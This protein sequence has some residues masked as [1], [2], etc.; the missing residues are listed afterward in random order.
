MRIYL[1]LFYSFLIK[2]KGVLADALYGTRDFMDKA[3][4]LTHGAQVISQ[5]RS[6]QCVLSK[7]SKTSVDKFFARQSGVKTQLTIRGGKTQ[8]VTLL[9]LRLKVKAHA[10]RRFV[11]ALKYEGEKTLGHIWTLPHRQAKQVR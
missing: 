10:K 6:N 9:A 11:I 3:S 7:K 8:Q 2:Y 4:S 1:I 5:L